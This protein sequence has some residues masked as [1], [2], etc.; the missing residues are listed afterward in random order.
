MSTIFNP[1]LPSQK[2]IEEITG[3][4]PNLSRIFV[5]ERDQFLSRKI[6]EAAGESV[7]K[8]SSSNVRHASWCLCSCVIS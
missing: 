5:D 3:E 1:S 6:F 2:L 4:Y 7:C 8:H